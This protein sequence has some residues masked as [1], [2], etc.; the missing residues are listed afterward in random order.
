MSVTTLWKH[1]VP[2]KR[3]IAKQNALNIDRCENLNSDII[4]V[5]PDDDAAV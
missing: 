5:L 1:E 4:L 2:P 3:Q